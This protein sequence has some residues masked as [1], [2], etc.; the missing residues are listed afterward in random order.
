[1]NKTIKY[2]I[3][4]SGEDDVTIYRNLTDEQFEF[5]D[6]IFDELNCARNTYAP[7][8]SITEY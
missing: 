1:M 2:K 6:S 4:V 8:M 3:S 7:S 5:I